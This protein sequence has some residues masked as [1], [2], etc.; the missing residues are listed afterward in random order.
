MKKLLSLMLAVLMVVSAIPALAEGK[1]KITQAKDSYDPQTGATALTVENGTAADITVTVE[2]YDEAAKITI[3]T[4]NFVVPAGTSFEMPSALYKALPEKG[5]INTYRYKITTSNNV[6]QT[7]Y[8]AQKLVKYDEFNNPIYEQLINKR[9]AN[10]TASSFGPHFRDLTPSLTDLWYMFTPLDLTRQGRQ[11][12][13]LVASNMYVIGEVYVDVSGDTVLITYHN[14][15]DGKGGNT[16][17]KQEYLNIFGSYQDVVIP[18]DEP[19]KS[20]IDPFTKFRFGVPFS[21]QFDLNG[22]TNVLMSVR[23]V[24]SYWKFPKPVNTEFRRFWENSP[25]NAALRNSML[26]LMDPIVMPT[27]APTVAPGK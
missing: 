17:Q 16:E 26:L 10:N 3:H 11:T 4:I 18:N 23:N 13:E 20:Y 15:Y 6:K 1:V 24:V 14:Y 22:D 2:V 25:A 7:F 8:F 27:F 9:Y 12:Y 5:D 21:I 19:L